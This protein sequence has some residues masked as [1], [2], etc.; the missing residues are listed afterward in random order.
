MKVFLPNDT[1]DGQIRKLV[2]S[3][4]KQM[5]GE[6]SEQMEKRG[7]S[8][9]LNFGI[10]LVAL[11]EKAKILPADIE[12]ADRLWHRGIRETMILATLSAPKDA[13]TKDMAEE[14]AKMIDNCELVEQASL[15]LFSKMP[16][17]S[18][19]VKRFTG[20]SN[21][22]QRALAYYTLG[23]MFRFADVSEELKQEG[24][25]A[26]LKESGKD[27]VFCLY[28][29]MAHLMRQMLRTDEKAKKECEKMISEFEGTQNRNLLWVA[30]ELKNEIDFL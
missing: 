11:R 21:V 7:V 2:R 1:L 3:F 23:W 24:I 19:L 14:W 17:A 30:S 26:A 27:D 29:G 25:K 5:D 4:R 9:R 22:Y 12:F 10:S 15:N 8:Y 18:W 13:M 28:R 6:I 20:E 16:D